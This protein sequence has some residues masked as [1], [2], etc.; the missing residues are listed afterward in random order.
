MY[1]VKS[2][3]T[4][5]AGNATISQRFS[6]SVNNCGINAARAHENQRTLCK[7]RIDE[8]RGAGQRQSKIDVVQEQEGRKRPQLI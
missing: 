3:S 1:K 5:G 4:A 2:P 8:K 6:W 7:G